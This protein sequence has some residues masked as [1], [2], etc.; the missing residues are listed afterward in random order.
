MQLVDVE[1]SQAADIIKQRGEPDSV[2][3]TRQPHFSL[4]Y[5]DEADDLARGGI[6][7]LSGA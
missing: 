6:A 5:V 1:H 3:R 2:L 4:A 7:R